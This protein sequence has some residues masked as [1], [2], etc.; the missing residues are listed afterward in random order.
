MGGGLGDF[1]LDFVFCVKSCLVGGFWVSGG[2]LVIL[3]V[4]ELG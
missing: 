4:F 2:L 3:W 1:L